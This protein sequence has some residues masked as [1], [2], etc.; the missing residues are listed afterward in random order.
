[1]LGRIAKLLD[2]KPSTPNNKPAGVLFDHGTSVPADGTAGYATGCLF[3]KTNGGAN[4]SL[5]VN[6]G[7]VTA[8]DFNAK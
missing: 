1:M 2:F 5:Y 3:Q 7:S 4:T 6:E 8:C